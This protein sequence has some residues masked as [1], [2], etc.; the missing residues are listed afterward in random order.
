MLKKKIKINCM[1]SATTEELVLQDYMRMTV[2][3][4]KEDSLFQ[5]GLLV[6]T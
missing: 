5:K 2:K 4:L 6:G 3:M 1:E